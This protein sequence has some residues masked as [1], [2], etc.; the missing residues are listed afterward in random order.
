MS[1]VTITM[2]YPT[3]FEGVNYDKDQSYEVEEATANALGD[4][5][6]IIK[7]AEKKAIEKAPEDKMMKTEEVKKK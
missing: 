5:C 2:N 7:K 1:K 6:V 3:F 4:S